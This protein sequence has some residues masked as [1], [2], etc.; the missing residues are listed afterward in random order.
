MTRQTVLNAAVEAYESIL[1]R[2]PEY[3][4]AA[5]RYASPNPEDDEFAKLAIAGYSAIASLERWSWEHFVA[6][7][8]LRAGSLSDQALSWH[9]D[10]AREYARFG[11][12]C[13]G[14]LFALRDIG[15]LKDDDD[16]EIAEAAMAG[17]MMSHLD[18]IHGNGDPESEESRGGPTRG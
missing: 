16:M 7:R 1:R 8:E 2:Y 11:C 13:Y 18:E 6:I 10:G 4:A 14:A 3:K 5:A 17:F 15:S 9:E 12:I